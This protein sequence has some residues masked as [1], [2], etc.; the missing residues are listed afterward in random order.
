MKQNTV[1]E[2][3][4][5]SGMNEIISVLCGSV[6][7]LYLFV[8]M[9]TYSDFMYREWLPCS[10]VDVPIIWE[11]RCHSSSTYPFIKLLVVKK[12]ESKL[13]MELFFFWDIIDILVS[14]IWNNDLILV[15][16]VKWSPQSVHIH[17]LIVNL[18]NTLH[19]T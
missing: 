16:I 8:I 11:I 19:H 10:N 12:L 17:L 9:K 4:L 14:N 2:S 5:N 18:V 1:S 15:Y 13:P 7:L 6:D 3:V